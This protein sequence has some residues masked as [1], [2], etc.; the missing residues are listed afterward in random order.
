MVLDYTRSAIRLLLGDKEQRER[1][2]LGEMRR[3]QTSLKKHVME[4]EERA[5]Q[6]ENERDRAR[7]EVV[8]SVSY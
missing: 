1:E 6:I 2:V 8:N 3:Q 4:L 7:R 5:K